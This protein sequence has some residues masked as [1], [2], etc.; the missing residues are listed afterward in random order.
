MLAAGSVA[1]VQAPGTV[2]RPTSG[3]WNDAGVALR[4]A[5]RAPAGERARLIAVALFALQLALN[6]G[7]SWIFLVEHQLGLAGI[8]IVALWLAIAATIA[9]FG[10]IRPIAGALLVPYIAWVTFATAPTLAIWQLNR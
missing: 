7:W 1:N 2:P 3:G 10:G 6:F 8:E 5:V 4:T 9:A